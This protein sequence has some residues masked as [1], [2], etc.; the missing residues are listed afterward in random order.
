MARC[1]EISVGQTRPEPLHTGPS[2]D[3]DMACSLLSHDRKSSLDDVDRA[4][5]ARFELFS[6]QSQGAL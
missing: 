1:Q 2:H 5:Y 3:E 6:H 4:K